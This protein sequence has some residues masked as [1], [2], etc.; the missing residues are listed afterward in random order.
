M[1]KPA[2]KQHL[3]PVALTLVVAVA[4]WFGWRTFWFLTDDAYISFRYASNYILGR[5][6]VWNPAPFVPVEGYTSFGWTFGL[7]LFWQLTGITPPVS[8]NWISL[9]CGLA[10]L[11]IAARLVLEMALP[12][13]SVRLRWALLIVTLVGTL[14]NRTFLTWLSS[15][16]ETA[17]VN[18]L[19]T[20]WLRSTLRKHNLVLTVSAA[21]LALTR[22]DGLL[23]VL[24]T[25]IIL[26]VSTRPFP[27]RVLW[28]LAVVPA[29][30]A[31]RFLTYGEWV[32]NTYFAKHVGAWP[33]AGVRYAA[34]FILEYGVWLWL[35]LALAWG[36]KE[37]RS[38]RWK[39]LVPDRL[40]A[41]LAIATLLAH[42]GYY[43]LIIGGDHFE[44]RVYSHLVPL[45]FVG[46]A[47][48]ATRVFQRPAAIL[49][50]V[51][52]FMIASWPIP[53]A[54]WGL[55]KEL[56]TRAITYRLVTPV[57]GLFPEPL[58]SAVAS[59][60]E[61]QTWLIKH[62][63]CMRHQEHKVFERY[64]AAAAPSRRTGETISWQDRGVFLGNNVG[65]FGWRLPNVAVIDTFGLN[66]RVIAHTPVDP[67][68]E[69]SMA[70][71]RRAPE[72]YRECFR[73]NMW[74]GDDDRIHKVEWAEKLSDAEII[75]CETRFARLVGLE[76]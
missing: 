17:L 66:D 55:T 69:R 8:A 62:F 4:A 58:H 33:E 74:F 11:W 34:C 52:A 57:A 7:A 63:V 73:P 64:L 18:L 25:P 26:F 53:W 68:R 15:G 43:T 41:A 71:D 1:K 70:H 54:H 21:L 24:A 30:L 38:A 22:P 76:R 19:I 13:A 42:V 49:G 9:L 35:L 31:W 36:V 5:G 45:L 48:M 16:M 65:V 23:Y 32:P 3:G 46:A 39:A 59:F 72:G 60:D 12:S 27:M 51:L 28:P 10:T 20:L 14:T 6:L 37:S 47:F 67:G 56:N 50:S 40:H 75:A 2:F 44:Y 61:M 29:H